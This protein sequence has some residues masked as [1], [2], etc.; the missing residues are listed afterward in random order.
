MAVV[1]DLLKSA[2]LSQQVFISSCKVL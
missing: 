2:D 1:S